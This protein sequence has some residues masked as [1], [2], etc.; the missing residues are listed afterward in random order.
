MKGHSPFR[1]ILLY[2]LLGSSLG[3]A[4]NA[5]HPNPLPWMAKE[6]SRVTLDD[7][8]AQ[9]GAEASEQNPRSSPG[10][11]QEETT[12][13]RKPLSRKVETPRSTPSGEPNDPPQRHLY[14]DLPESEYPIEI[15]VAQAKKFYERGG[16][17]V[18]DAREHEEYLEGHVRGA[19][20]APVDEVVA[21][22]DWLDRT[23]ADPR[24]IM[25]YCGGGDCEISLDLA[26]EI[27]R[28]G[29]R[30][31]LVLLDGYG[32]WEEAGQ[33]VSRGEAP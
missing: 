23:A 14:S 32:G 15:R 17:L 2:I 30:R 8:Q 6:K 31:V 25:V 33:P 22:L 13:H 3:V 7:L 19:L 20:S 1:G 10:E 16:L 9:G 21:D 11:S 18:L 27:T 4:Y 12:D 26:L 24:P 5:L 28:S 29:H